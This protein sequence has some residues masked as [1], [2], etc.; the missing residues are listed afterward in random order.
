MRQTVIKP[1][2]MT[3]AISSRIVDHV[4][5]Y[6]LGSFSTDSTAVPASSVQ[7]KFASP[8][9]SNV[10]GRPHPLDMPYR[11][12]LHFKYTSQIGTTSD[13]PNIV[14]L[15]CFPNGLVPVCSDDIPPPHF[16]SFVLT[17]EIGVKR[18]GI[19]L[20]FYEKVE[21]PL[22]QQLEAAVSEWKE[23]YVTD[24][25][26]EYAQHLRSKLH[27]EERDPVFARKTHRRNRS[28]L[29]S[30]AMAEND[31]DAQD[32]TKLLESQFR[33]YRHLFSG[34]DDVYVPMCFG[35]ISCWPFYGVFKD[36]LYIV[37]KG[38][39]VSEL[40]LEDAIGWLC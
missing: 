10:L 16:H 30:K 25:H 6:G 7:S 40:A 5:C 39:S 4:F 37:W 29:P 38:V 36:W 35:V 17:D 14:G 11:P 23:Q 2:K 27:A 8:G 24:S 32:Y 9:D 28:D 31:E 34:L 21:G 12:H 26:I 19:C 18:Y 33:P 15:F 3:T 22:K 13:M 20:T 1:E